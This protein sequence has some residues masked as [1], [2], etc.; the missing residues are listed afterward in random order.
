MAHRA[1]ETDDILVCIF[2]HFIGPQETRSGRSLLQTLAR[3][4]RCC[5]AFSDPALAA[6]WKR[7]I[8]LGPL[9]R[10]FSS[11]KIS[12]GV[13]SVGDIEPLEWARFQGY[14]SRIHILVYT[15]LRNVDPFVYT[16]LKERSEG[17][18]LLPSLSQLYWKQATFNDPA[19]IL[20]V[21]PSLQFVDIL[22]AQ[23]EWRTNDDVE[24]LEGA[25]GHSVGLFLET[26]SK[27]APFVRKLSLIGCC[28]SQW[29]TFLQRFQ[30]LRSL[31]IGE[32]GV[33]DITT[34]SEL[35]ALPA[36]QHL[37]VNIG[38][39][40]T[41]ETLLKSS[42]GALESLNVSGAPPA[43][44][45]LLGYMGSA[46]LQ[47]MTLVSSV[48]YTQ[49]QLFS[50][51]NRLRSHFCTCLRRLRIRI[52]VTSIEDDFSLINGI[53]PLLELALMEDVHI[54]LDSPIRSSDED[55][56]SMAT[57]WRC[58]ERF[59]LWHRSAQHNP[60]FPSLEALRILAE[61]CPRLIDLDIS[62]GAEPPLSLVSEHLSR[63]LR[64]LRLLGD[65]GIGDHDPKK[66]AA[67]ITALFPWLR[68]F[69]AF[70]WDATTNSK[71]REVKRQIFLPKP[72]EK[73]I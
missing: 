38:E 59:H 40:V 35:S 12:N 22:L 44:F 30:A 17:K 60:S 15:T 55:V 21:T 41:G 16:C 71:W 49:L 34:L 24:G 7:Q 31:D 63:P 47:S 27:D 61:H 68:H 6:L 42:F 69:E 18:P 62:I 14:A 3:L 20:F 58:L 19:Y 39:V 67:Y 72:S 9:L 1:L 4:A 52:S 33:V 57:A 13:Y 32:V 28:L 66:L 8:T 65:V 48:A 5:R 43:V 10:V 54:Q 45:G 37:S 2:E 64:S 50:C 46:G 25:M 51:S 53:E 36:L 23:T 29:A 73:R 26:I 11:Y 56:T 70:A